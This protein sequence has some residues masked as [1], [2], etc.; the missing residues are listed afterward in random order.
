M[1]IPTTDTAGIGSK[2]AHVT[3]VSPPHKNLLDIYIQLLINSIDNTYST[4]LKLFDCQIYLI[5][6][7]G[8]IL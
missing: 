8:V 6:R 7:I 2:E 1:T 3:K 4:T 5:V